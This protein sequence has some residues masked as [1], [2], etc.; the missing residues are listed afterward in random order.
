MADL[1]CAKTE[2]L[3]GQ[4]PALANRPCGAAEPQSDA[5]PRHIIYV[6]LPGPELLLTTFTPKLPSAAVL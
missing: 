1:P 6:Q 4:I 3:I 5:I 2:L